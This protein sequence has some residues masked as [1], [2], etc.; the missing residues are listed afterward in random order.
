M[1]PDPAPR[2]SEKLGHPSRVKEKDLMKWYAK[3]HRFFTKC[4]IVVFCDIFQLSYIYIVKYSEIQ[5]FNMTGNIQCDVHTF[6]GNQ[7]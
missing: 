6:T 3:S 5:P 2:G 1:R 4:S 7:N